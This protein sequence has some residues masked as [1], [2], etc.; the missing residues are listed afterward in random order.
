MIK[1]GFNEGGNE[2]LSIKIAKEKRMKFFFWG[3]YE[4]NSTAA[5]IF[6]QKQPTG[7]L[8]I[9]LNGKKNFLFI[10]LTFFTI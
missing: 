10:K 9:V 6:K 7:N 3:F 5:E 1:M 4:S 8:K 2:Y